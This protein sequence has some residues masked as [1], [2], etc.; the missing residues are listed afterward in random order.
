MTYEIIDEVGRVGK[1]SIG[2]I[3]VGS[4]FYA[5]D[6]LL[7]AKNELEA[8][9]KLKAVRIGEWYGRRAR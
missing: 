6:G 4:L 1:M 2:D 7:L 5:D 8:R 9:E 3:R